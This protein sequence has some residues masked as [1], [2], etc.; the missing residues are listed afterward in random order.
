MVL[1]SALCRGGFRGSRLRRLKLCYPQLLPPVRPLWTA[2]SA[3]A[4]ISLLFA[5]GRGVLSRIHRQRKNR[6]AW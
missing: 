6:R 3:M 1:L 5:P 4:G 2:V